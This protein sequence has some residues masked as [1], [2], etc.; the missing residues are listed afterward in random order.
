MSD[1]AT[2][3]IQMPQMGES[4]TEGT[5]LE[6]R[7]HEGEFVE[8]GETVVEVSTDKIDAEVPAPASGVITRI[9]KGQDETIEVGGV[10]AELD[11]SAEP[12]GDGAAAAVGAE[13]PAAT[14]EPE[15]PQGA[16]GDR[17]SDEAGRVAE[18]EASGG[19]GQEDVGG[20]VIHISM[21]E[22]GESVTE[23]TVLEWHKH[24]GEAVAEGETVVEVSTDK[25]DAEVPAPTSGTIT[26]LLA[27]PDETV[28]VGQ[29]L[30]EMTAGEVPAGGGAGDA[31][32][33]EA[34]T[35]AAEP[36][37]DGGDGTRASPVARRVAAANGVDLN[38]VHG[39]GPAGKV[40]KADVLA[41]ANGEQ[42]AVTTAPEPAREAAP[43]AA[44]SGE[45]KPLRGP[46]AMLAQAMNESRSMPTATSFRALAVDTLDAK[47]R[48][49]NE[50]L[51]ER[52]MK[53]SFTHLIAWAIVSAAQEWPVMGRAY[54]ESDGKPQVI[55]AGGINLGIAVDVER[56]DGSRSLMVPCIT[57]ADGL[58]FASFHAYYEELISKTRENKLTA[59]DFKGTN[60]TLTNPGGLG[61][62]ASVPRLLTGQGTIVATG[63]IAYPSEWAHAPADKLKTLGVSKVMTMTSTYD[64]RII[65]GAESGSFLRRIDQLLQGEDSFYESV[66]E[67]LD[68]AAGVVANAYPAAASAP[69]LPTAGA[70]ATL[71]PADM[72]LLQAVQAATSLLKAY[73]THGHLAARLDP[74]GK[75]P[76]GD[77]AI[78]PENLNLTPELMAKIPASILR[79]GVEGETLL[80]A[81][82]RMREAYSGTV[83]YQIEHL[84]SHQQRMW[85]RE[86]IETGAHR[87]P[88]TI[89]EKRALL[90]RLLEVFQFERFLQ[91]AY[92]GQKMFSIEGL[93]AVVPMID[94]LVTLARREGA[95][96]VVLGMAHRGRLAVLAHNLG[97]SVESIMAEFEGAQA[98][99]RVKAVA[100]IP[101]GGTGDVKYHHGAQGLF[102]TR[103]DEQIRVRLYPNPSHLEFVDPVVTGGARA[104]Q[105]SLMGPRLHHAPELAVPLLL[106][107]DAAFPGQ[108][109]VAETLNLQALEGYSTGGTVH[110]ITDNQVGFTTDPTEARSTPYA[111][112]MAKGFNVPIIHVNA[113]DVEGCISAI[114]LAMAYR[115]R[116]ARD[117]VIDLIGYRRYGHNETDEPAYTQPTMAAQIAA[118][119][120]V[121][122]I[123]AER[124]VKEGAVTP[125][126]VEED[127]NERNH[128]L[129]EIHRELKRKIEA[130][131]YEAETSTHIATGELDRTKSPDV[132]TAV[133]AERLR[134]LNGELL[135]VPESFAIHRKLR[136]PLARRVEALIEGGIDY[137]HAE[138]LALASL[139]TEGTHIRFTGQDTIRGTFS[140]RHL[141]YWDEKTGLKYVPIQN[142]SG[143]LAPFELHNSPLSEAGCL[144]FEYGYSAASPSSLVLWE[145]QFG[146]FANAAQVI[147]DSFIVSGESKWG[148][149]TRLTLLLPHGYEGGGPEHSNARIER[150]IQ[151]A[152]EGN[153]RL[154]NPTTAGQYFHL[155]R[156]QA[157]IAKARP[158]VVFTPKGLLRLRAASSSLGDLTSGTF[159]FVL[160][161]PRATERKE[162]IERLVLCSGK[163]YYD[164]D[165][166]EKREQAE[167]VAIAR[168]ELLYPFA[169]DQLAE[170]IA[171]YPN[172]KQIVWAQEEPK[173][174]G[175]WSVMWRRLPELLPDGVKLSYVG[176]PQRASP[177]EGYPAAHRSEQE[178]I[179]LTAL[180]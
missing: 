15:P 32:Q 129:Q 119:P 91:R 19:V 109:V 2:V 55:E 33:G 54:T 56:K 79:I 35:P 26:K 70:T 65:Q 23:G 136:K 68:I 150:F 63:S 101:H 67:S 62:V 13:V 125:D 108:G 141:A 118:H 27:Q 169:R 89:E 103:D 64:H 66:A 78:E 117:I 37:A 144:G 39:S 156:R 84:S 87:A 57:G 72:E 90:S 128:K 113:D 177:G 134:A 135:K 97:R 176:R 175:A 157:R 8:E 148:Q 4:V 40:T 146:D 31:A 9:L 120:P 105:S 60:I 74:L 58:D 127:A 163:L 52:A 16:E 11:P 6:W 3:E 88:L 166:H 14:T 7:K 131:E 77:P 75:E 158:L 165:G 94:E 126:D 174:M 100:A 110:I 116:W 112:D 161:D 81:L 155:L 51:K 24:E 168:V 69:A 154:A 151:L 124:L 1:G 162:R 137:G 96:E 95:D 85:L 173:N 36:Q 172:L 170:L 25:V 44:P 28:Q 50:A 83:A 99:E 29:V 122:E 159:E 160:D 178:R 46:A 145:A 10:L 34:S 106:H 43:P 76:R 104:F 133:S 93:D 180:T 71:A 45:A 73:R 179:V 21:P 59:D 30:A 152:A 132:D 139:L 143:A 22:M 86:M 102:T 5:V 140:H 147:I 115:E 167:S 107:G 53:V 142:L 42:G 98:L 49:L 123:Y 61:T 130:G 38:A 138:A 20:G 82:P 80:E 12:S 153:I 18:G 121:S 171:T 17:S 41:A 149:T 48:A 92:L 111:S 47:R 164:I 114:R